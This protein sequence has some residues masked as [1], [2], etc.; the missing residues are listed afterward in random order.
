MST[1]DKEKKFKLITFILLGVRFKPTPFRTRTLIWR[2]RPTRPSPPL[3]GLARSKQRT[4]QT[5]ASKSSQN[6]QP[7][8]ALHLLTASAA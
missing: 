3:L 2:L 7:L 6:S 5:A 8:V 4:N 1:Q